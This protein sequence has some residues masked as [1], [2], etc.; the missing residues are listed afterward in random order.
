MA[1]AV[2][3]S[4][5]LR[6]IHA[7]NPPAEPEAAPASS[8]AADVN[9]AVYESIKTYLPIPWSG[10]Q[11]YGLAAR[12]EPRGSG[13]IVMEGRLPKFHTLQVAIG[14]AQTVPGLTALKLNVRV[15]YKVVSDTTLFQ[16]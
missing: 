3:K 13:V 4:A 2:L 16:R 11:T 1:T 15:D 10:P 5:P 7:F 8:L 14:A 9:H 12:E 6:R